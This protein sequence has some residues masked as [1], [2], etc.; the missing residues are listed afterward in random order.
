MHT[1]LLV[2]LP[3]CACAESNINLFTIEDDIQLGADLKAQIDADPET[4]PKLDPNQYADAYDHVERIR[5]AVL[6]SDDV[7]YADEFTWEVTIID[8]DEVLNAFAA[9]GGY[10]WVYTGLVRFLDTEDQLTGVLGHEIAHADQRHST[11]QLTK[12]YGVS[13]LLEVAFGEDPGLIADIAAGLVSL[14]FS[15]DQEAQ[16]DEYSVIYLC[17]TAYAANGAAGF[18]ELLEGSAEIPEFLS[19]HPSSSS[20]VIDIDAVAADLGCS[21][22][23][24][25]DGQYQALISSL[26]PAGPPN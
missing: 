3:L 9:P 5:D 24:N 18:F 22:E 11:E 1:R 13:M 14:S 23:P 21:T 4:Y 15:R 6:A 26:P 25:P 7:R 8:D 17:D 20:R 16:A 19:T 2:L 12:L 10:I